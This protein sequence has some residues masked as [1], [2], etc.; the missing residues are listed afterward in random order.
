MKR[1]SILLT[2]CSALLLFASCSDDSETAQTKQGTLVFNL[3]QQTS[4]QTRATFSDGTEATQLSYAVYDAEGQ[5]I[6][7]ELDGTATLEN[8]TAQVDIALSK[9]DTYTVVFWAQSEDSPYDVDFSAGTVSYN[10]KVTLTANDDSY[11]AFYATYTATVTGDATVDVTLTR[12]FAQMNF[13][14]ND[15]ATYLLNGKTLTSTQ[16]IVSGAYNT[17]NLLSGEATYDGSSNGGELTFMYADYPKNQA[18]PYSTTTDADGTTTTSSYA[19]IGMVYLFVGNDQAVM[20]ATLAWSATTEDEDGHNISANSLPI[21]RNYRTNIFGSLLTSDQTY[22]VTLSADFGSSNDV[23]Y[24]AATVTTADQIETLLESGYDNISLTLGDDLEI[25]SNTILTVSDEQELTIDLNGN[26]LTAESETTRNFYVAAGGTLTL[27]DSSGDGMVTN[28]ESGT[29]Y[30]LFDVYGTLVIEG[31]TYKSLTTGDGALIKGRS[32]ATIIIEGGDFYSTDNGEASGHSSWKGN[33]I[34][35]ATDCAVSI[36]AG[37]TFTSEGDCNGAIV[38]SF[39]TGTDGGKVILDDIKITTDESPGIELY[40]TDATLS[41]MTITVNKQ[42]DPDYYGTA[43]GISGGSKVTVNSGTYSGPYA[44]YIY[45]SGGYAYLNGGIYS[46]TTAVLRADNDV[47]VE[48]TWSDGRVQGSYIYVSD[49]YYT[50][51]YSIAKGGTYTTLLSISGG[52][53]SEA[54]D[55]YVADGY[56]SSSIS[57]TEGYSYQVSSSSTSEE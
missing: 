10:D 17:L 52:Y 27:T 9:G 3:T 54:P 53:F 30:G 47:T 16:V 41:N 57:N 8:G 56:T 6:S 39:C 23:S 40:A 37:T 28:T 46:G 43:I 4:T 33:C 2:L 36:A 24:V 15:L 5:H 1:N 49:G 34:I 18:F 19:W 31:G 38:L 20:D 26:T 48:G 21:Q 14:S 55:D 50:G 42:A 7:D 22:Q 32:G 13:G 12:P 51:S 11:D 29:S 25:A 45:S 44:V 35:N